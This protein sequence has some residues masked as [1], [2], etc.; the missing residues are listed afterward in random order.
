MRT[1]LKTRSADRNGRT[2][3]VELDGEVLIGLER[4]GHN[5]RDLLLMSRR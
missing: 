2:N 3:L 5:A 1:E 4:A